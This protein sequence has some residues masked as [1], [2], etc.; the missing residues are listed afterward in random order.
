M[1]RVIEKRGRDQGDENEMNGGE[2]RKRE[3]SLHVLKV[4][5]D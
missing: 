2:L 3:Q 4:D 5:Y 1:G